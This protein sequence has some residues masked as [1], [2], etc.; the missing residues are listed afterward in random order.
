MEEFGLTPLSAYIERA[1]GAQ[2][3]RRSGGPP[4]L[5][6]RNPAANLVGRAE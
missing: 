1:Q 5:D 6:T 2:D 3:A 4:H